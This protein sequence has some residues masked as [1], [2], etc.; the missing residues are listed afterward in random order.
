MALHEPLREQELL[1][2]CD[3]TFVLV[4]SQDRGDLFV[5]RQVA[6]TICAKL[7]RIDKSVSFKV[8]HN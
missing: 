3:E 4:R 6:C 8:G 5:M 7:Q 1:C 2:Y